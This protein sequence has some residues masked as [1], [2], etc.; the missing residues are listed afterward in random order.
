MTTHSR[1]PSPSAVIV[2]HQCPIVIA[3]ELPKPEDAQQIEALAATV[4]QDP[5][6]A[7]VGEP[8]EP[9]FGI[10]AAATRALRAAAATG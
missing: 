7:F 10:D 1:P 9:G 8:D 4:G 2:R 5:G 6:V 3:A